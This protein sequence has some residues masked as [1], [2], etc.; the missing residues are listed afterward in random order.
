MAAKSLARPLTAAEEPATSRTVR[1]KRGGQPTP[2]TLTGF[3]RWAWRTFGAR[4]KAKPIDPVLEENL[5]KAHIRVRADEYLAS[6]Y[7]TTLVGGIAATVV[8]VVV[9][10]LFIL[11]GIAFLGVVVLIMLP[12]MGSVGTF[13]LLQ[14]APG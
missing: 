12:L 6:V 9:G 14:G 4:V 7:A 2:S 8:G 1:V 3:Q 10:L 5:V 11:H 13:F